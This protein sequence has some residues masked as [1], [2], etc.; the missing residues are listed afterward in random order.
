MPS[1]S[2]TPAGQTPVAKA[3]GPSAELAEKRA[4]PVSS[5][6]LLRGRRLIEIT[7]N[8]E[9]YRLQAT[10]QGKLILTK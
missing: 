8:G 3:A 2:M 5:D 7:H 9:I 10:R 1:V 4:Q 6:S